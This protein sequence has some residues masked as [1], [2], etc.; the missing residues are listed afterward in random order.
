[1]AVLLDEIDL[2]S[3]FLATEIQFQIPACDIVSKAHTNLKEGFLTNNGIEKIRSAFANDIYHDEP[4]NLYKQQTIVRDKLRT[5]AADLMNGLLS[6]LQNGSFENPQL[7]Q[8]ILKLRSQLLRSKGKKV[9]GYLQPQVKETVDRIV[10]ELAKNPVLQKM[11][12]EWCS[13]EQQKY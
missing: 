7:E 8:L 11:Y 3:L 10:A 4:Q 13:L 9:Y 12:A 6:E 1:M 5:T 2:L